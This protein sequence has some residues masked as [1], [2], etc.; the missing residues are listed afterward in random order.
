MSFVSIIPLGV[1]KWTTVFIR[2]IRLQSPVSLHFLCHNSSGFSITF[3]MRFFPI[4]SCPLILFFLSLTSSLL[5]LFHFIN[6]SAHS[7]STASLGFKFL[8]NVCPLNCHN[9]CTSP[10]FLFSALRFK[11]LFWLLFRIFLVCLINYPGIGFC[12][13]ALCY[14]VFLW[15]LVSGVNKYHVNKFLII[16][17]RYFC[18]L[19]VEAILC[20]YPL[21]SHWILLCIIT[22][23]L[24]FLNNYRFIP[25]ITFSSA[26]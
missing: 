17:I 4:Q 16:S 8:L 23:F 24:P 9:M 12:I 25:L 21:L 7:A 1:R 19:K 6:F 13:R 15:V 20:L 18:G 11:R 22:S 2:H 3:P 5:I 26:K 10:G 14:S